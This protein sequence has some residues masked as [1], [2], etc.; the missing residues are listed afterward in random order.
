MNEAEDIILRN[1]ANSL[2][3]ALLMRARAHKLLVLPL[4]S[5]FLFFFFSS[6]ITITS[7][8]RRY[9]QEHKSFLT[10]QVR[11]EEIVQVHGLTFET[12]R[13]VIVRHRRTSK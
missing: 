10:M 9:A 12:V 7:S 8:L 11:R 1:K 3:F 6:L 5:L 13:T 2:L 4:F